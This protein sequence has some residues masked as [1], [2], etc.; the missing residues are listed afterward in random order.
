MLFLQNNPYQLAVNIFVGASLAVA[1]VIAFI[2]L[3]RGGLPADAG[4]PPESAKGRKL[5]PVY[6]GVLVAL[7]I[8]MLLVQRNA[9]AG[10][11]LFV[12]GG[13]AFFWLMFQAF[14]SE[15]VERERLFV[16]LILMFFS[17]LFWAF[18]EQAG[19]SVNNFTDRNVDRVIE[20]RV[21][22]QS[23]VGQTI[24]MRVPLETGEAE[25]LKLPPLTQEQLGHVSADSQEKFTLTK[26]DGLR[27]KAT[28]EGSRETKVLAWR[29]APTNV[30][31]GIGGAEIPASLFQA[32]NPIFI[33]ILGLV[34]TALWSFLGARGLEPNTPVKFSLGLLQLG[35]GFGVLWYGA[36][37]ADARGMVGI[38][39]LLLGYLLH[40]TGELC[41]SPVGLSMV[42]KLSPKRIV[43]TVMGAWFLATAFS[44][45]LAGLIATLTGVGHDEGGAQIIPPPTETVNL[46]GDVFGQIALTAIVSAL[47]CFALSPLLRKWMHPESE[48]N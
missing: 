21:A 47:I 41:I 39:W 28:P 35:L 18:F 44:N 36:Q 48:Q 24:E 40:T 12:F 23:D 22:S 27:G 9:I 33:I 38:S 30:G 45:Y 10:G 5:W 20:E 34:F 2:A 46:Y 6:L 13:G 31:M 3:N 17:M 26:L 25:L 1:G 19:S 8:F 16:V 32:A 29:V 37:V 15:K 11:M 7:P 14:K 42:T 43:S 4:L